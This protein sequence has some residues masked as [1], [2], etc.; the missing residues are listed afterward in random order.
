V[1]DPTSAIGK[2]LVVYIDGKR[3]RIGTIVNAKLDSGRL[4]VAADLD[5]GDS[6][7]GIADIM[8]GD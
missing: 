5:S 4:F 6:I 1:I 7:E 3:Q 2:P 8:E